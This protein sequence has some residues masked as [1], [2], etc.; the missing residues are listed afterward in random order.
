MVPP[1][2]SPRHGIMAMSCRCI[3]RQDGRRN[4]D[5]H[6]INDS[7][8]PPSKRPMPR[9]FQKGEDHAD[10]QQ[11]SRFG[12]SGHP[13][14][15]LCR[16]RADG[17]AYYGLPAATQ[18]EIARRNTEALATVDLQFRNAGSCAGSDQSA[19]IDE[20]AGKSEQQCRQAVSSQW[21]AFD[22][23]TTAATSS[24]A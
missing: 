5:I 24:M 7:I 19:G 17:A 21:N 13:R 16:R 11:T 15:V 8:R 23:T 10:S 14:L 6:Q 20:Q 2:T 9:H 18:Y 3:C 22:H 12:A 1:N 4:F